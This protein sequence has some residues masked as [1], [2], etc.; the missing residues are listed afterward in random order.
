MINFETVSTKLSPE[1]IQA[2]DYACKMINI[3]REL[4]LKK[5]VDS[6]IFQMCNLPN[7][8]D[9]EELWGDLDE[10]GLDLD[11]SMDEEIQK[12]SMNHE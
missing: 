2:I 12:R 4:L 11:E 9:L 10:M 6:L 5:C 8:F 3:S 1:Y 7:D